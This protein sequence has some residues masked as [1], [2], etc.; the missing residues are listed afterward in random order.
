MSAIATITQDIGW[1]RRA[2]SININGPLQADIDREKL[3]KAI[4]H[5]ED[6]GPGEL[7]PD[8]ADIINQALAYQSP[9]GKDHQSLPTDPEPTS[10]KAA[11]ED[12]Q[13]GEETGRNENG[14]TGQPEG[15]TGESDGL[16]RAHASPGVNT[17]VSTNVTSSNGN[18]PQIDVALGRNSTP[19]SEGSITV[20]NTPAQETKANIENNTENNATR[21]WEGREQ[22]YEWSLEE[23]DD[24]PEA[25]MKAAFD[26]L[27]PAFSQEEERA[28]R[29][30]VWK[31]M[32]ARTFWKD[33]KY[34]FLNDNGRWGLPKRGFT[35]D[36][37][38][39]K[40]L[41]KRN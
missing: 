37:G 40:A 2:L 19:S 23:T 39:D 28:R 21:E 34:Y 35:H 29:K 32:V 17:P 4:W 13:P 38:G 20:T 6:E 5:L 41:Q 14:P 24:N 30:R 15:S 3:Q 16:A 1:E 25:L 27:L 9:G 33:G 26:D 31:E 22:W 8:E 12:V 36:S 18:R 11:P 7:T 10:A